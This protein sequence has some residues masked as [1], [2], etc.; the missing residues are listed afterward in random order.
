MAFLDSRQLELKKRYE[1]GDTRI[2][3]LPMTPLV[4]E[5]LS[6]GGFPSEDAYAQW[7]LEKLDSE[8]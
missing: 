5:Y 4:E 6:Q 7:L 8:L 3:T 2:V 1:A